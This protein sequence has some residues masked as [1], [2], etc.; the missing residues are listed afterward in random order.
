MT[1]N[2]KIDDDDLVEITGAGFSVAPPTPSP[3]G[4]R[5]DPSGGVTGPD[6]D[7]EPG[8]DQEFGDG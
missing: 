5:P 3:P 6:H 4:E 2:R 8:G 7:N 1:E